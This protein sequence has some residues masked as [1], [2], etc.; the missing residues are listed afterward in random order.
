[1]SFVKLQHIHIFSIIV[2]NYNLNILA[3]VTALNYM[4]Q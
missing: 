3:A 2:T 1:M 4:Y